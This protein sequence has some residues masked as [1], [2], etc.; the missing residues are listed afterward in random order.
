MKVI[1]GS[2]VAGKNGKGGVLGK[3]RDRLNRTLS[4]TETPAQDAAIAVLKKLLD[5]QFMLLRNVTLEGPDVPIPLILV[6]PPGVR[7]IY[8]SNTKGVFRARDDVWEQ[9]QDRTQQWT[10]GR[11]NL[12]A[13]TT[14]MARAVNTYLERRDFP[15]PEIEPVLFFANPGVHVDASRPA[16]RIVLAD[17]LDRFAGGLVQSP[18]VL[19]SRAVQKVVDLLLPKQAEEDQPVEANEV[20]DAFSFQDQEARPAPRPEPKKIEQKPRPNAASKVVSKINFSRR[21]WM[22]LGFMLVFNILV[23]IAFVL[24]ILFTA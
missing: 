14:L 12:M 4:Q 24:V 17:A 13:R 16:V 3:A 18:D 6:G 5:N 1:D 22:L 19:D 7:V 2:V 9:L 15:V 10:P 8:A 20:R 23:L 11:P 21:Q